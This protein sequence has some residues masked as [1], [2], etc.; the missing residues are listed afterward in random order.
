MPQTWGKARWLCR[1]FQ[2]LLEREELCLCV[3]RCMSLGRDMQTATKD[4][5]PRGSCFSWVRLARLISAGPKTSWRAGASLVGLADALKQTDGQTGANTG[6]TLLTVVPGLGVTTSLT[7]PLT[8]SS[9]PL[10]Y[11]PTSFFRSHRGQTLPSP[12]SYPESTGL[13]IS[14]QR[15]LP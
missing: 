10:L 15:G 11:P 13:H 2:F 5:K 7:S 12:H 3:H 4:S 6:K 9:C 8:T 14:P 1:T